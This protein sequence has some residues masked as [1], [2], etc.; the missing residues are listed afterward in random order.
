MFNGKLA[1]EKSKE[2]YIFTI[3]TPFIKPANMITEVTRINA[4]KM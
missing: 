2:G 1:K 4:K 3:P